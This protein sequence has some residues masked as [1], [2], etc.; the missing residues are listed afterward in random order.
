V[1]P[2]TV[3]KRAL[4]RTTPQPPLVTRS[5]LGF[6]SILLLYRPSFF[7]FFFFV[8]FLGRPS[9]GLLIIK[10]YFFNM[11]NS[12]FSATDGAPH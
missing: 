1:V 11:M 5:S 7:F 6:I 12:F 2:W 4:D 3:R 9:W 10:V 8:F